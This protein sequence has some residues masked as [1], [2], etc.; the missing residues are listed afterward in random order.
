MVGT[1][2]TLRHAARRSQ[3][4]QARQPSS[5]FKS[6]MPFEAA[7]VYIEVNMPP[8]R[9]GAEGGTRPSPWDI[10]C[11]LSALHTYK[12]LVR[13]FSQ[14][15][16]ARVCTRFVSVCHSR[17]RL[18]TLV[19]QKGIDHAHDEHILLAPPDI[20]GAKNMFRLTYLE[21]LDGRAPQVPTH[22]NT[23]YARFKNT[24][25]S[26]RHTLYLFRAKLAIR[27]TRQRANT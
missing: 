6:V 4:Y 16:K 15:Q 20:S 19:K 2:N 25:G 17:T 22:R 5:L 18:G 26:S 7:V 3:P 1:V 23:K 8:E 27:Q 11:Y 21:T 14:A 10:E 12:E 13:L 24:L 9:G